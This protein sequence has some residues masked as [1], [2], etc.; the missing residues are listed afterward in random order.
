MSPQRRDR[1]SE[2]AFMEGLTKRISTHFAKIGSPAVARGNHLAMRAA[3][4]AAAAA[5]ANGNAAGAG[6][7]AV[8]AAARA[9]ASAKA[10]AK[11]AEEA[12][13][14]GRGGASPIGLS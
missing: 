2:R 7:A 13:T 9:I 4:E 5:V 3:K 6:D 1:I 11:E 12:A 14:A 8:A 10:K